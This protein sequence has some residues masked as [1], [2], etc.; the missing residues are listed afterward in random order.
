MVVIN[1]VKV[2]VGFIGKVLEFW[3]IYFGNKYWCY[4]V[5]WDMNFVGK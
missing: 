5:Y 2:N 3:V 4:K 1:N